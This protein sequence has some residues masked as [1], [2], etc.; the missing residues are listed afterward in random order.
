MNILEVGLIMSLFVIFYTI[1]TDMNQQLNKT[2]IMIPFYKKLQELLLSCDFFLHQVVDGGRGYIY[3]KAQFHVVIHKE[4]WISIVLHKRRPATMYLYGYFP[5]NIRDFIRVS[6]M[7]P[8]FNKH[9][10]ELIVLKEKLELE[11]ELE[12]TEP[13]FDV[14][15]LYSEKDFV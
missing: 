13:E 7:V 11:H 2:E 5:E 1:V 3:E 14:M 12:F 15:S 4:G 9:L 8:G 10:P 6:E